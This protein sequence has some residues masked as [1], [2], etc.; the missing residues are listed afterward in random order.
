VDATRKLT[1]ETELTR[2]EEVLTRVEA[3]KKRCLLAEQGLQS[4]RQAL[5]AAREA[6]GNRKREL[7]VRKQEYTRRKSSLAAKMRQLDALR[8]QLAEAKDSE[9]VH[10]AFLANGQR[11]LALARRMAAAQKRAVHGFELHI[12]AALQGIQLQAELAKLSGQLAARKAKQQELETLYLACG[13][14]LRLAKEEARQLHDEANKAIEHI[15]DPAVVQM[16]QLVCD[17]GDVQGWGV[18]MSI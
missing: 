2:I 4:K 14:Q 15:Q 6:L 1:L 17:M 18:Y 13:E 16:I 3:E 12:H 5:V 10:D 9:G 11:Q 7:Q 8:A